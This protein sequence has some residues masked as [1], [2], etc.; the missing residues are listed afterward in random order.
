M[1]GAVYTTDERAERLAAAEA[2]LIKGISIAP[3]NYWAHLWLGFIQILTNRASRA[4]GELERALALNR[5]IGAAHAWIGLAK[6][7][8]GR[9][10]ETEAH[11]NEAFRHVA[12]RRRRL[13]YGTISRASRSSISAPTRRRS[14]CFADQST[15]AGTTRSTISTPPRRSRISAASTRREA[16]VKAGLAMA[17]KLL[18]RPV[19]QHGRERQPDLSRPARAHPRG[20]PQSRNSGGL[21]DGSLSFYKG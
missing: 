20:S 1:I 21:T 7:T 11:V 4:I 15:P 5:N 6:I 19:S 10:E 17:P 13:S 8:M 12:D 16:E 14:R 18:D 9:A 3:R 2:L